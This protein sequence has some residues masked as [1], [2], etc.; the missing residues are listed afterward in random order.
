[1]TKKRHRIARTTAAFLCIFLLI[2]G[3]AGSTLTVEPAARIRIDGEF[4]QIRY[5]Q[6]PVS[7]NDRTL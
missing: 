6:Y 7:V 1:M 4:I 5:G 3:I 2:P